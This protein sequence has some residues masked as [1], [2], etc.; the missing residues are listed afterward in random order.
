MPP[1]CEG[2]LSPSFS[3][4]C[5]FLLAFPVNFFHILEVA[6]GPLLLFDTLLEGDNPLWFVT[7]STGLELD[8]DGVTRSTGL[9][10][11]EEEN[12]LLTTSV[13]T[14]RPDVGGCFGPGSRS[15]STTGSS[16]IDDTLG[17]FVEDLL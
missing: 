1:R 2:V 9:E 12:D 16:L 11:D 14:S 8:E 7:G 17:I 15:D 6:V 13:T 3:F 4:P 10:L 5:L